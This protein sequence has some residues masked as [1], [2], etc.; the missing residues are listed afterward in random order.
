[1]MDNDYFGGHDSYPNRIIMF[2]P[3]TIQLIDSFNLI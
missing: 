3:W 2:F 1:M